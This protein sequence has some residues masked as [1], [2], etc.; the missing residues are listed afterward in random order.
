MDDFEKARTSPLSF[1]KSTRAVPSWRSSK[2]WFCRIILQK[3]LD[4]TRKV[5]FTDESCFTRHGVLNFR[6]QHLWSDEN[7]HAVVN[8]R[9]QYNFSINIWAGIIGNHLIE[10]FE[11]PNRLNGPAYLNF[12][13]NDLFQLIDDLPLAL[14]QTLWFMPDGAPPHYSLEVREWLH[15]TFR[16]RWIGSGRE[17]TV[18]WPPRSPEMNPLD[19]YFWGHLKNVVYSTPVPNVEVL[20]EKIFNAA[21]EV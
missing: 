5:L 18:K 3:P 8:G 20:R 13:Q 4:F 6:N 9:Y 21:N 7:S 12:L 19:F 2:T 16:N 15:L 11:L 10:P 17:A 1:T 14:R